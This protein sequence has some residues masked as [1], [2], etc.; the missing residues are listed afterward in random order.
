MAIHVQDPEADRLLRDFA[1]KRGIGLTA[2][3]KVAVSEADAN[4]DKTKQHRVGTL[5]ER[6]RPLVEEVRA[7][8]AGVE[9]FDEKAFMD[10]MW[11]END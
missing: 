8:S 9:P 4:A 11:G 7:R 1:R 5:A 6:I 10:D 3:I 2:A